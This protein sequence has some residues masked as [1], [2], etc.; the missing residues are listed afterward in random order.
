MDNSIHRKTNRLINDPRSQPTSKRHLI[1]AVFPLDVFVGC[2]ITVASITVINHPTILF[3][4]RGKVFFAA[5]L[6]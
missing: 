5:C 6:A 1:T 2:K 4:R 3:F